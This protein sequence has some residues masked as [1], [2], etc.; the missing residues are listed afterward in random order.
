M[1]VTGQWNEVQVVVSGYWWIVV[2]VYNIQYRVDIVQ[3]SYQDKQNN[4]NK[5]PARWEPGYA[6]VYISVGPSRLGEASV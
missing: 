1:K 5:Q 6:S 4:N 2:V 3:Y